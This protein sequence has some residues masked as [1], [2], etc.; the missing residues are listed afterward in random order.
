M[1]VTCVGAVPAWGYMYK[2]INR[3]GEYFMGT[4]QGGGG[5]GGEGGDY[6]YNQR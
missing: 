4:Q 5:G 6:M 3:E 1:G 2:T